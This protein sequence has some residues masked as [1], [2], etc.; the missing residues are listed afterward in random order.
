MHDKEPEII[1]KKDSES[2]VAIERNKSIPNIPE[3]IDKQE[4]QKE[5]AK[6]EGPSKFNE[7]PPS[8]ANGPVPDS[9]K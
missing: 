6:S 1:H 3:K 4:N 5:R 9:L 2:D 8:V 7:K